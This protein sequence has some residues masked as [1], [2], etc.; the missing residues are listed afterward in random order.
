MRVVEKAM[1]E[2]G[3]ASFLFLV[4]GRGWQK[5]DLGLKRS[6][7][8]FLS[9]RREASVEAKAGKLT[10]SSFFLLFFLASCSQN[11]ARG[12][13]MEVPWCGEMNH[14]ECSLPDNYFVFCGINLN[15]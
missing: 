15:K 7:D 10:T 11:L 8:P 12:D 13:M 5:W 4:Q 6:N 9:G 3:R 1:R 14:S 2:R